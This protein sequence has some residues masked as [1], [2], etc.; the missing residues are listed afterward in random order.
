MYLHPSACR[1]RQIKARPPPEQA[2]RS[3]GLRLALGSMWVVKGPAKETGVYLVIFL[4][5]D[6]EGTFVRSTVLRFMSC[7]VDNV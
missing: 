7:V 6:V 4:V 5:L 2:Q 1:A 3:R